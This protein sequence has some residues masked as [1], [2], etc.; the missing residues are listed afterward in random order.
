MAPIT[1]TSNREPCGFFRSRSTSAFYALRV[2]ESRV[3]SRES[4]VK[5]R[6]SRVEKFLTRWGF[7]ILCSPCCARPHPNPL[8]LGGEGGP[9][10]AFS[11]AGAGRVRGS[12]G[13]VRSSPVGAESMYPPVSSKRYGKD[14][15][16][17]RGQIKFPP[18]HQAGAGAR[19]H[20]VGVEITKAIQHLD[21]G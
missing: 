7:H 2:E 12:Q 15:P 1:A 8:P 13:C 11:S 10:P 19:R 14:Q 18:S 5:S 17:G 20:E 6:R 21:R 3:E 4:K 16:L 9:P